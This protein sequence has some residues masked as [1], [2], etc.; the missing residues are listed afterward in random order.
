MNWE[1]LK[2]D[3]AGQVYSHVLDGGQ[4]QE[5]ILI[6]LIASDYEAIRGSGG[7]AHE[8]R[9]RYADKAYEVVTAWDVRGAPRLRD[10]FPGYWPKSLLSGRLM[11]EIGD[12]GWEIWKANTQG[13]LTP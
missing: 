10:L 9:Q 7:Q 12:K 3:V 11:A 5:Q 4:G 13:L 1:K 8:I 6:D 2:E